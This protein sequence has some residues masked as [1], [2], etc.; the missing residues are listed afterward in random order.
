M[1]HLHELHD[2]QFPRLIE[3][4]A[5]SFWRRCIIGRTPIGAFIRVPASILLLLAVHNLE[6]TA[7]DISQPLEWVLDRHGRWMVEAP[8]A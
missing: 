4:V 8:Y 6:N 1:W 3:P 2:L 5:V 7:E